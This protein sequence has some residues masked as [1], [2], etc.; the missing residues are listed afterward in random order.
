MTRKKPA[1]RA[2]TTPAPTLVGEVLLNRAH[3]LRRIGRGG[4]A[5]YSAAS[6]TFAAR[7]LETLAQ[8]IGD[9]PLQPPS[10]SPAAAPSS[11]GAGMVIV[12]LPAELAEVLRAFLKLAQ[13]TKILQSG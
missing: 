11:P 13:N 2:V 6:Y 1:A 5:P 8:R 7:E 4:D 3:E 10:T 12:Q 9:A